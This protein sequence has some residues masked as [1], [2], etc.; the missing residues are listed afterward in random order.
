M[1]TN[2]SVESKHNCIIQRATWRATSQHF[3]CRKPY[4]YPLVIISTDCQGWQSWERLCAVHW[5]QATWFLGVEVLELWRVT[6]YCHSMLLTRGTALCSYKKRDHFCGLRLWGDKMLLFCYYWLCIL[7]YACMFYV[8]L[9]VHICAPEA[10][11]CLVVVEQSLGLIE[12]TSDF[13]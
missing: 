7:F 10:P 5:H 6:C 11:C 2:S 12:Q 13:D 4:L 9:C 8:G 1:H 3:I